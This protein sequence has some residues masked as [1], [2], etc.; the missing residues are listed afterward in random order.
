M[1]QIIVLLSGATGFLGT[2]IARWLLKNENVRILALVRAQDQ[3]AAARR[4]RREWW[5]WPELRAAIAGRAQAVPGDVAQANL[6]LSE[7][8]YAALAGQVSHIVH[9][10]ADVRLFEPLESLRQ[11]NVEGTRNVLAL[12]RLAQA[13]HGL[14]RF[15]HISTAY[16]CGARSEPVREEELSDVYGFSSPYERSKYE[17]ELLVRQAGADFPVSIFRP[18][19]IVGDSR[20]GAVKSFNTLYYPLRLY[21]TGRASLVPADP[22]VKVVLVPVDYVAAAVARLLF[23]PRAAGLCFH[24]VPPPE[25]Q[26]NLVEITA[27]ARS[28]ARQNMGLRLPQAIF[29]HLPGF[30]QLIGQIL[31]RAGPEMRTLAALLPYFRRKPVFSRENVDQLLGPYP[32]RWQD[33]LSP[34]LS[35]AVR[36]SF[37]HRTARTAHEQILFRLGSRSKPVTYHDLV[38]GREIIRTAAEMRAEILAVA[39]GLARL[40]LARG[41]RVAILGTNNSRYFAALVGIGLSGAVSVPL[42]ATSPAEE[43]R[44]LLA[45]CQAGLFL[46]GSTEVLARLD[47][48]GF[49]GPVVSFCRQGPPAGLEQPVIAWA[50]FLV[51]GEGVPHLEPLDLDD[52]A[53]IY[54]TSGTTGQPKGALFRH[55]QLRWLGETL[56]SM[57]PWRERN[58]W[59][60]Y[61]SYL[62]MNHVVEGV[63]ASFS[64][65]YVPA[66]LDIYFLEDFDGLPWALQRVRPT[67]F[68]SVPRFFEKVQTFALQN[69]LVRF[70]QGLPA[71]S[72]WRKP[73]RGLLSRG[74]LRKAGLDGARMIIVGSA[75][76]DVRLLAFFE[77]L[78]IEVL[79]AYGL[80]EAPLVTLNRSGANRIGTL[81]KP[82]PETHLR[83]LPDGEILVRG[84][85]VMSGYTQA[86]GLEEQPGT[87]GWLATG[88]LGNLDEAGYLVLAGRKKDMLLTSYAKNI[89]PAAVE[90]RLRA[91]P[92]VAEALLV[93]EGRPYCAALLWMEGDTWEPGWGAALDAGIAAVNA[94]LSHPEQVKRWAVLTDLPTVTNGDL[95]GSLKLKRTRVTG[96]L[97]AVIAALYDGA[98]CGQI[99]YRG[100]RPLEE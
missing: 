88:D 17:A 51:F 79:D 50:D 56:A 84:P 25:D 89:F 21:L 100:S 54:Y 57:Y 46:V 45:D 55:A 1:D 96:R 99:R 10:A 98:P 8:A 23:D 47:E 68:F 40:G 62:P 85:Q 37:W 18:G 38:E 67:I 81:G 76:S 6:G 83:F 71:G 7:E 9:C 82:L 86:A 14:A 29:M 33:L 11:V 59:G 77:D 70:Y 2:Q 92:G 22:R 3:A 30:S 32:H 58:R 34:L 15:A 48:I 73:L 43:I 97:A 49:T 63:L 41:D 78:G 69:R 53:V 87:D 19:M 75:R 94:H 5:D 13:V 90:A 61:L 74:L 60:S 64:P 66:A 12:A 20:S 36:Y 27:L 31:K 42:Y 93:G 26:P 4:L 65:Y 44:H 39:A 35:Y 16:V 95:T 91:L 80:S 52:P 24:L 72:F 28:W